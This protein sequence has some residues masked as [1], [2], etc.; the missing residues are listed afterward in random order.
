LAGLEGRYLQ[1]K[2]EVV[3]RISRLINANNATNI[4][5]RGD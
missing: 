5:K 3:Q 1:A 4:I 2:T